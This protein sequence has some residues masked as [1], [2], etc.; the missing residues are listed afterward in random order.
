M[1][2][3][4]HPI[5]T[6]GETHAWQRFWFQPRD[7]WVLSL[8]RIVVGAVSVY[9]FLSFTFELVGFFGEH[10][11]LD[12]TIVARL[13]TNFGNDQVYRFSVLQ[14]ASDTSFLYMIHVISILISLAM[15]LGVFSRVTTP[16]TLVMVL[17][18][19]HR[20]PM[21]T[22]PME[23]VLTMLLVYLSLGP[24]G[25][26][27]SFDAWRRR[28]RSKHDVQPSVM[29]N[30]AWRL[31]QVHLAALYLLI[32]AGMLSGE[33]WWLGEALLWLS[34]CPDSRILDIGTLNTPG[35]LYAVNLATHAIV[36]FMFLYGVFMW[37]PGAR[38]ILAYASIPIWILI[39]LITGL[40]SYCALMLMLNVAFWLP[41]PPATT[42]PT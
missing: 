30:I 34:A 16:L 2:S 25:A 21:I 37:K 11:A 18:Y 7:P 12:R 41:R 36:A 31:I 23:H 10:G 26:Y 15:T 5:E 33:V 38:T 27:L 19:V 1:M 3:P 29:A 17:S 13:A 28:K 24:T 9:Y 32:G 22:G 4:A 35:W 20:G 39:G 6:L 40:V 14:L 42:G 8:L